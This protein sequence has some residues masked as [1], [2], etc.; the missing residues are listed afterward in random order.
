VKKD[1]QTWYPRRRG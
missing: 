1:R